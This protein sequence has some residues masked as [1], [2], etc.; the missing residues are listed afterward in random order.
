M[1]NENEMDL[2]I[3][4][5]RAGITQVLNHSSGPSLNGHENYLSVVR[6]KITGEECV[7]ALVCFYPPTM[8]ILHPFAEK[9]STK[10]QDTADNKIRDYY[11]QRKTGQEWLVIFC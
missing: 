5:R 9:I 4:N 3:E 2:R 7:A 6:G 10:T 1:P 8:L 11:A